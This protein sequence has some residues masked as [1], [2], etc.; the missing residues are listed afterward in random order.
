M[1]TQLHSRTCLPWWIT[2]QL[3]MYPDTLLYNRLAGY[4]TCQQVTHR[5]YNAFVRNNIIILY[6][7]RAQT[8]NYLRLWWSRFH[9]NKNGNTTI[10]LRKTKTVCGTACSG[11]N[12][13][14]FDLNLSYSSSGFNCVY[15]ASSVYLFS[16]TAGLIVE[17]LAQS[18]LLIL[19]LIYLSYHF[20][21]RSWL[22][23][24]WTSTYRLSHLMRDHGTRSDERI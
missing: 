13:R 23:V 16:L 24:Q 11:W 3:V 4:I 6:D 5:L 8:G 9:Q 17:R 20:Q 15:I 14:H 2:I 7:T 19:L 10:W 21:P 22:W 12:S 18:G 1:D